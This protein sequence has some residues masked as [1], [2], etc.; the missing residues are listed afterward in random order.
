VLSC[1]QLITTAADTEIPF[2]IDNV[3]VISE[4]Q[5]LLLENRARV[6][7][8]KYRCDVRVI[9]VPDM[10]EYGYRDILDLANH[11]Y[12]NLNLGYG[13]GRNCILITLSMAERDYDLA[14][15]GT[16]ANSAFTLYGIDNILDKHILPKLKNN[17]YSAA[18]TAFLS[19]AE[20]YF[21]MAE[22]GKP[23]N[24]RTDPA[25][26]S[27]KLLIIVILSLLISLVICTFWRMKMKTAT[28]ATTAHNYIPAGGFRLTDQGD[29]FLFRTTTRTRIQSSSSSSAGRAISGRSG[30]SSGRSGKF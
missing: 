6:L 2:I 17:E 24:S 11:F 9:I 7:S 22:D 12:E 21:Q 20:V 15:W 4:G 30:G 26:I 27:I 1:D 18:F 5:R 16:R 29:Q 28:I 8:E 13:I 23:F 10:R 14:V 3:G 25:N 19:R